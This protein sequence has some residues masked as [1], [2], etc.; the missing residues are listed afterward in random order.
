MVF[1]LYAWECLILKYDH[2]YCNHHNICELQ[3]FWD[4]KLYKKP[5]WV[6]ILTP[7]YYYNKSKNL[8]NQ[9]VPCKH[10]PSDVLVLFL[11]NT[12][13]EI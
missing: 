13:R 12:Q 4:I 6:H 5:M 2:L 10:I 11:K 1:K 7:K 3:Y 8:A 9:S